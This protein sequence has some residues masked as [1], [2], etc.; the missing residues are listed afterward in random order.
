[1]R[2]ADTVRFRKDLLFDGAVQLG[3]FEENRELASKAAEHYVFHGPTYHGVEEEDLRATGHNLVDTATFTLDILERISGQNPDEPFTMAIAGYGTGKSH[4]AIT[5]ACLLSNRNSAVADKILANMSMADTKI[6]RQAK[7]LIKASDRPFLVVALNGMQDFDL[8]AEIIR[9]V[10]RVLNENGLDTAALEDLRPRFRIAIHFTESFFPALKDEFTDAFGQS[11]EMNEII[12]ALRCQDEET[13]RKVSDIYQHKMGTPIRAVGLESLNDFIRVTKETYCGDGKPFAG[14]VIIFDEF[15]RYLEFSVQKPHVAGS[16][17]LQQLFECVQANNDGVFLLCFIQYELR[18]Y[19]SRVAPEIR[20]DLNRYV[21]RYDVVRKIRLSTNLETLIANLLEK[22]DDKA[23]GAHLAQTKENSRSVQMLMKRWFPDIKNHALW[24]DENRFDRIIRKGCWP[25]H[26]CSSWTLY[27]LTSIGKSLQQ[28]SA[29]SLLADVYR[30]FENMQFEPGATITPVDLCNQDLIHEFLATER[31]GQQGAIAHGYESVLRKYQNELSQDEKVALKAVL[32]SAKIG[33]KVESKQ[34]YIQALVMFSDLQTEAIEAAVDSLEREYAVL[35]WNDLLNQYEIAGDAIP[36][37]TFLQQ[38]GVRAADIDSSR[39]AEIFTQKSIAWGIVGEIYN[40]D[41]GPENRISTREWNY[42]VHVANVSILEGQLKFAVRTWRDSIEVDKGKG[43]LIYCYVGPESNIESVKENTSK[44]I[45]SIME[46]EGIN[47]D[48]GIPLAVLFLYD[49]DATFGQRIAEYWVL[50][51][52][53]N[54]EESKKYEHFV[55]ERKNSLE[56]E[57]Q[58]QFSELE[59]A[60]HI[61]F[62]TNRQLTE[63][64]TKNTL[65]QLFDVVYPRRIQFPFD[66]FHTA[67]GNAVRDSQSFTRALFMG[68]LDHDWITSRSPQ[69]RNRAH[70]VLVEAWGTIGSDGSLRRIPSN[71]E[72]RHIIEV[73]ESKLYS[74]AGKDRAPMNMGEAMTLLCSP[75]YGCNIASAGLLLAYFAGSRKNDLQLFQNNE[76]ISIDKWLQNA[77]PGNF[78]SLPVL[79]A[80]TLMQASRESIS[81][82]EIFLDQWD[83]ETTLEGKSAFLVK[84]HAL[85][86]RIPIPQ[87][88]YYR[89]EHLR[90]GARGAEKRLNAFQKSFTY[91]LEKIHR[92]IDSDDVSL[93]SWG[94]ADLV[95]IYNSMKHKPAEWRPE[96]AAEVEKHLADA[97]EAIRSRFS[98]WLRQQKIFTREH[99]DKFKHHM[100]VKIGGNLARLGL[101]EERQQLDEH[102]ER[103]EEHIDFLTELRT[104]ASDIDNMILTN[105]VTKET[106]VS[107]LNDW[108]C[109]AKEFYERLDKAK[110]R[111]DK[112]IDQSDIRSA[113]MKLTEFV[114]ACKDQLEFYKSRTTAV[115]NIRELSSLSDIANWRNEVAVLIQVYEGQE[116]NVEDLKLVQRQLDLIET[117]YNQLDNDSL[118]G[119]AFTNLCK[120]CKEQNYEAFADDAPPL[121]NEYIYS[122]IMKSIGAKREQM[123]TDWISSNVPSHQDIKKSDAP[124]VNVYRT[125][126]LDMPPYL[127]SKQREVAYQALHD[128]EKRLDELEVEGILHRFLALSKENK[129]AF[130]REIRDYIKAQD[131]DNHVPA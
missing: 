101:E 116:R 82:W 2:L 129:R 14:I 72:V 92:G 76:A 12:E 28:R 3:W 31:Y 30:N 41:F 37:K 88:L 123:A 62:A 34:D 73:L 78:L 114:K 127:S 10:L 5:L 52:Q 104:V 110:G 71:K 90:S 75:P 103:I 106:K 26:P 69:E 29:L 77:M 32:I 68:T 128:C 58:N 119:D 124:T 120:R 53:M 80:T 49:T 11:C 98:T 25:L 57:M 102:V 109:Q 105:I 99:L 6:G 59:R 130:L 126:L 44:I 22:R 50:D 107:V 9:Q 64:R 13:F 43:Q 111:K 89:C 23:L 19:I 91:A 4:L 36:R 42:K 93:L 46:E 85:G 94:A 87:Q 115:Y 8:N 67:R 27:K 18:A 81:E 40:T 61:V 63:S 66:G 15:G 113:A 86:K 38:L 79:E 122:G 65:T 70:E 125:Q 39:R 33:I 95:D 48:I 45:R 118:D 21:T 20:E 56:Q 96:Q 108:L 47:Y 16:G 83:L 54:E 55:L 7:E 74:E 60:R 100:Q 24:M 1:M 131:P 112:D 97:R 117:H 84:E 121:D 17:A 35:E 51:E